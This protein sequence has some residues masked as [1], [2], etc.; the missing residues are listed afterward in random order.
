MFCFTDLYRVFNMLTTS[1]GLLRAEMSVNSTMSLKKI[2]TQSNSSALTSQ[3]STLTYICSALTS[4]FI[5]NCSA[6]SLGSIWQSNVSALRFSALNS[7]DF[8]CS[9]WACLAIFL[10][11]SPSFLAYQRLRARQVSVTR[12]SRTL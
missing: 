8:T 12:T 7:T 9:F 6:T 2:V 10:S 1:I 5:F 11:M 4:L 3:S